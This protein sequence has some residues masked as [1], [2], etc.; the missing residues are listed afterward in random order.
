MKIVA[1]IGQKRVGKDLVGS[2]IC[3]QYHN[4]VALKFAGP[5]KEAVKCIFKLSDEEVEG[6]KK[7][8]VHPRWKTTPREIMQWLGTDVMQYQIQTIV[9]QVKRLFWAEQ[10]CEEIESK[11]MDNHV[12]VITDT[13]FKHELD[14][15]NQ[16]FSPSNVVSIKLLRQHL[17]ATSGASS[18]QSESNV[19]NIDTDYVIQNNSTVDHLKQQIQSILDKHL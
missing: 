11:H 18:H 8:I 7:D 10:M 5:L 15:L 4:S 1:L 6:D 19:V 16:R 9:P 2:I 3:D 13:R 12:V 17:E 14:M